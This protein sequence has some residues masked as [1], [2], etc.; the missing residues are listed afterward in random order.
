MCNL[1]SF[2]VINIIFKLSVTKWKVFS[3]D[4][5]VMSK[6]H[7]V[8]YRH[9]S[10]DYIYTLESDQ[11]YSLFFLSYLDSIQQCKGY[12]LFALLYLIISEASR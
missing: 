9:H 10:A 3:N 8:C 7:N 1:T 4:V 5:S 6:Y 2:V 12:S 11:V